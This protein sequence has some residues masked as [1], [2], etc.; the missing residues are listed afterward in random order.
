MQVEVIHAAKKCGNHI[1]H[2]MLDHPVPVEDRIAMHRAIAEGQDSQVA[3]RSNGTLQTLI[4]QGMFDWWQKNGE[5]VQFKLG[6]KGW[7]KLC[8]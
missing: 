2:Q 5:T 1:T 6:L 4:S 7:I 8:G 3:Q